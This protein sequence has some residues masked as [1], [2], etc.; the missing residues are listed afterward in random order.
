MQCFCF[1]LSSLTDGFI[2]GNETFISFA[3]IKN[4]F[5]CQ[6]SVGNNMKNVSG[7]MCLGFFGCLSEVCQILRIP[8]H[9]ILV[10]F[11]LAAICISRW[12]RCYL[13]C[14]KK[15]CE[16]LDSVKRCNRITCRTVIN[17]LS[18][19]VS[20]FQHF[21]YVWTLNCLFVFL[22]PDPPSTWLKPLGSRLVFLHSQKTTEK[23][24]W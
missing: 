3:S 17:I 7:E 12:L 6:K 18:V 9:F 13:D 16:Y 15:W 8:F 2:F 23:Y 24:Q 20:V 1:S 22:A 5:Q 21:F 11:C 4:Q 19:S 10:Y 14:T